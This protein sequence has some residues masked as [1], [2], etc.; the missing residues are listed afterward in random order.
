VGRS[1]WI[2]GRQSIDV[3]LRTGDSGGLLGTYV[4]EARTPEELASGLDRLAG[5]IVDATV[6]W[7]KVDVSAAPPARPQRPPR[8]PAE[9]PFG[10]GGFE[11][12]QP[13]SIHSDELEASQIGG[14]RRL[15]FTRGVRVEQADMKLESNRLEAF[16]PEKAS[17]PERLVASGAGG[18]GRAGMRCDQA[19]Y[20]R[21]TCSARP[22]RAARWRGPSGGR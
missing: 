22:R 15:V 12:D 14:A 16:Y 9:N 18:A 20:Y 2:G 10:L 13:L 3:R 17:Q 6:A 5:E 4:A 1:T 7:L 19:T 8:S 11:S 21:A